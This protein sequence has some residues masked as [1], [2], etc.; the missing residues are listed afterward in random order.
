[1]LPSAAGKAEQAPRRS[2]ARRCTVEFSACLR[3]FRAAA[4]SP[5]SAGCS[6]GAAAAGLAGLLSRTQRFGDR[7]HQCHQVL[8]L[9]ECLLFC[10]SL[11]G[12]TEEPRDRQLSLEH[13]EG[14]REKAVHLLCVLE[15][16]WCQCWFSSENI[17][18]GPKPEPI[19]GNARMATLGG[20]ASSH[21]LG[22]LE[23]LGPELSPTSERD[24]RWWP[25]LF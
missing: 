9:Q 3:C 25:G 6:A 21:C 20:C 2:L 15:E 16:R 4:A 1:M 19:P 12:A 11:I 22:V 18:Q 17:E 7:W 23:G 13:P 5:A 24:P 8:S 14:G 10:P